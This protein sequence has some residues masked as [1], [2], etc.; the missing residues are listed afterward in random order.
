MQPATLMHN[1][2]CYHGLFK[3]FSVQVATVVYH[4]IFV[5]VI[6]ISDQQLFFVP[7]FMQ[8]AIFEFYW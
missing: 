6:L 8:L 7:L 3:Y 1:L 5:I 2:L 4:S